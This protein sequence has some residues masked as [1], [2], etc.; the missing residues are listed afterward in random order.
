MAGCSSSVKLLC[1]SGASVNASDFVSIFVFYIVDH[2]G[3]NIILHVVLYIFI[4]IVWHRCCIYPD[5]TL[6]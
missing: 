6:V 1:D 5:V 2:P 4:C 3:L